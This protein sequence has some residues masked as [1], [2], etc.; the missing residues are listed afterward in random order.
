M[1]FKGNKLIGYTILRHK[2]IKIN[3]L[4]KNFLLL[5]TIIIDNSFRDKNLGEIL[6]YFNNNQILVSDNYSILQCKNK[7]INFYKKFNWKK[8]NKKNLNFE[9]RNN[10][11]N[12]MSFNYH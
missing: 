1:I 8:I 10:K 4:K 2:N 6:M 12:L 3:N 5:D 11:L 7:H 9:N